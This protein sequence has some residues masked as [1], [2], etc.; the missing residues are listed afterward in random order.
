MKQR[1]K[2]ILSWIFGVFTAQRQKY[3]LLKS[4]VFITVLHIFQISTETESTS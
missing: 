4:D 3:W 1:K 2:K